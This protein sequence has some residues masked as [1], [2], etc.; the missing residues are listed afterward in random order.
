MTTPIYTKWHKIVQL[1]NEGEKVYL[2]APKAGGHVT[3]FT[4]AGGNLEL[5]KT[6]VKQFSVLPKFVL[7]PEL[8]QLAVG[9]DYEKS[10]MDMKR[11]G[12]LHLPFP[13]VIVEIPRTA[14][15]TTQDGYAYQL[16]HTAVLLR[17][18]TQLHE[19][20]PWEDDSVLTVEE[21]FYGVVFLL[22]S[23]IDGDYLVVSSTLT[24]MDMYEDLSRPVDPILVHSVN[25]AMPYL[26]DS[27]AIDKIASGAKEKELAEVFKALASILLLM[28]TGGVEKEV[29]DCAKL[30][31]KRKGSDKTL[32]SNHTYIRL[33]HVYRSATGDEK[34]VYIPG[35]SPRP[36]WRRAH[37]WPKIPP[38]QWTKKYKPKLRPGR[39][40]AYHGGPVPE[41]KVHVVKL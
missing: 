41:H 20:F 39:L 25:I 19:R 7:D 35:K 24:R 4:K 21:P 6:Y 32:I 16:K 27:L 28:G 40:V 5:L 37:L 12:V 9:S 1:V 2:P 17:D 11:A 26:P 38:E 18:A 34:D 10:L 31:R 29:I 23:D 22:Y 36:H 15:L 14:V 30:N 8:T 3:R 33:A 13:G